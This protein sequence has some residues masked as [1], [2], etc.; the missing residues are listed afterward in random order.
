MEIQF[1]KAKSRQISK[2]F[3]K[4]V[5][6]GT[7]ERSRPLTLAQD[8]NVNVLNLKRSL[9]RRKWKKSDFYFDKIIGSGKF[10]VVYKGREMLTYQD[11]AIK[12][13]LKSTIREYEFYNNLKKEIEI[14]SRLNHKNIVRL[15]GYFH[16]TQCIYLVMEYVSQGNLYEFL[17]NK[18][19]LTEPQAAFLLSQLL[20]GLLYLQTRNIIHRDIK[21]ENLLLTP[22]FTL[23]ICD[24]GWATQVL[25]TTNTFCGTLHYLPPEIIAQNNYDSTAEIWSFGIVFYECLFGQPPFEATHLVELE[26]KIKN[27]IQFPPPNQNKT[28]IKHQSAGMK[29]QQDSLRSMKKSEENKGVQISLE[30]QIEESK[31]IKEEN[32]I[33]EEGK[34]LILR[35]LVLNPKLRM[36]IKEILNHF[37]FRKNLELYDSL[38]SEEEPKK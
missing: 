2:S 16:D 9:I 33:S 20:N 36:S 38:K 37:W 27:P 10:G 14:Q 12:C 24:F 13:V 8:E 5:K 31:D 23:K 1:D 15:Y 6:L 26:A 30:A 3:S 19:T 7:S 18:K 25:H 34:E 28:H 11:V 21:L 22:D 4:P 17:H 32:T 35:I 29:P